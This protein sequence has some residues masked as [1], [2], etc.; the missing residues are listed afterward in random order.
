MQ[1]KKSNSIYGWDLLTISRKSKGSLFVP[2]V[3]WTFKKK[4]KSFVRISIRISIVN[5]SI[6]ELS[7]SHHVSSS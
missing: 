4:K 6:L 5:H 7:Y 2:L 1:T 3:P